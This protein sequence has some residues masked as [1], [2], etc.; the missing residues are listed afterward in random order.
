MVVDGEMMEA[1][2]I[3]TKIVAKPE[4]FTTKFWRESLKI[5]YL[6][7]TKSLM[8]DIF[9]GHRIIKSDEMIIRLVNEAFQLNSIIVGSFFR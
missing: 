9:I 2:K 5:R 3:M 7:K 1:K 4:R 8:T 6:S